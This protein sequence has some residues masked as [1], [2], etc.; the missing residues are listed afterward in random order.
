MESQQ[1]KS[2]ESEVDDIVSDLRK[3]YGS[4]YSLPKLR[5]WARVITTGNW[6]DRDKHP[7]LPAFEYFEKVHTETKSRN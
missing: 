3:R 6:N 5:L 4:T 2:H 1:S 7:P